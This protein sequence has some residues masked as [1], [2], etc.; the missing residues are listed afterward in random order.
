MRIIVSA[1]GDVIFTDEIRE[2]IL[3]W[4]NIIFTMEMTLYRWQ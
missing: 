1:F 3:I 4:M 2:S